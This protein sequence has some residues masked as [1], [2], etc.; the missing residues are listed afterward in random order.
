MF[1]FF[2]IINLNI[3][4]IN[5]NNELYNFINKERII[6]FDVFKVFEFEKFA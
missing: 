3:I 6:E 4:H 5:V 1:E 2:K